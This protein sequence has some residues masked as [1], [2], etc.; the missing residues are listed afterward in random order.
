MNRSLLGLVA[1][2][3][4]ACG[5]GE[6]EL[7]AT[8][9]VGVTQLDLSNGAGPD[10]YIVRV[11]SGGKTHPVLNR[12][13]LGATFTYEHTLEGFAAFIPPVCWRRS[14][15]T[16]T[17]LRELAGAHTEKPAHRPLPRHLRG[18]QVPPINS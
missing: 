9:E 15:P 11:Q 14:K 12:H 17:G 5:P 16:R 1:M 3:L 8:D 13:G 18:H 10:H 2:S 4:A 6:E 7:P